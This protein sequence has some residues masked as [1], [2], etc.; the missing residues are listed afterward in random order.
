LLAFPHGHDLVD[1]DSVRRFKVKRVGARVDRNGSTIELFGKGPAVHGHLSHDDI[2]ACRRLGGH[3]DGRHGGFD[4][5]EPMGAIAPHDAWA[6][7][8]RADSKLLAGFDQLVVGMQSLTLRGCIEAGGSVVCE[9]S[10]REQHHCANE[11]KTRKSPHAP[12]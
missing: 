1:Y 3:H 11:P 10:R 5:C 9:Q 4:L 8:P 7:C 2:G 6:P 12:S